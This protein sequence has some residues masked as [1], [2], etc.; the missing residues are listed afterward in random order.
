MLNLIKKIKHVIEAEIITGNLPGTRVF[1]P[2]IMMSPSDTDLPFIFKRRQFPVQ[3]TFAITIIKP[4][5]KH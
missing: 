3:P 1:I 4:Q 2:R 5:G